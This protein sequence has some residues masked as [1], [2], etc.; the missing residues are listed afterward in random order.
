MLN[1]VQRGDFP[2]PRRVNPQVPAALEA[3]CLKAMALNPQARYASAKTLADDV[4][5]WL[6]DEAVTAHAEPWPA[7]LGRWVRH[8]KGLVGSVAAVVAVGLTVAIASWL[9]KEAKERQTQEQELRS[10]AEDKQ[11]E[12]DSQRAEAEKQK[13]EADLQRAEAEK[14][15]SRAERYLYC[16]RINLAQRAWQEGH[17]TRMD[18]LLEQTQ[19]QHTGGEDLRGFERNYLLRLRQASLFSLKGHTRAVTSVAFSPDG[20]RLASASGDKTVKVWDAAPARRVLTLK[21][22]TSTVTAWR[23]APTA[24]ASPPAA[25]TRR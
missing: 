22:H 4:E 3:I 5:H 18:D 16:S 23:S 9:V 19:P 21:G 1:K 12:A 8:H 2:P 11:V 25:G 15:H 7:R 17:F 24:N 13:G 20:K 6:A 14:Q 10:I